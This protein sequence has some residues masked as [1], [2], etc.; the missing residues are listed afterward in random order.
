[1]QR[2]RS[3]ATIARPLAEGR[4]NRALARKEGRFVHAL[5]FVFAVIA[6]PAHAAVVAPTATT[7]V[8]AFGPHAVYGII[9]S[10][11]PSSI[12]IARHNGQLMIVDITYARSVGRTGPLYLG[13]TVGIFGSYAGPLHFNANAVTSANGIRHG[14][15][16]ED[17]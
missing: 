15:W 6:T 17:F 7:T 10:I 11:A 14:I 1:M 4:R 13:R 5:V 9:R 16:P 8:P 2:L 3:S 12:T